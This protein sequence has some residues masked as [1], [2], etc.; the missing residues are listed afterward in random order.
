VI[1]ARVMAMVRVR[2]ESNLR[3][4]DIVGLKDRLEV[5]ITPIYSLDESRE[6]GGRGKKVD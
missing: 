6:K 5:S 1:V 4:N 3:M 2:T